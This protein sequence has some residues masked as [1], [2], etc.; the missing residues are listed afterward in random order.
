MSEMSAAQGPRVPH[1][2]AV[3]SGGGH[4]AELLRLSPAWSG[5]RVT[6]VVTD[7]GYRSELVQMAQASGEPVPRLC[8]VP[9]A[10]KHQKLR[11]V[12]LA[13]SLVF[14]VL[15]YRPDV[16]VST[17][18]APGYFALR[19]GRLFGARTIW[20]DSIANA[21]ALSL[22]GVLARPHA[23]LWLTQWAHLAKE[24]GVDHVGAV[25]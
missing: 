7:K 20:V 14:I 6:Y 1:V 5:A 22:S 4:W 8:W 23:D 13:V 2:L 17:G 16:V 9:D 25:M 19:F 12:W 11:L 15:R 24:H 18:A 3:S 21:D 10:N